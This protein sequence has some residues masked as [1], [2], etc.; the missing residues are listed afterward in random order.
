MTTAE[1]L[2]EAAEAFFR[3]HASD[4]GLEKSSIQ[5]RSVLNWGGFV[6][7]SYHVTDGRTRLHAKLSTT[8]DGQAALRRWY[9]LDA[10]LRRHHA[11]PVLDRLDV[12]GAKGLVFPWLEGT[13]PDFGGQV[14]RSVLG[15]AS[16]LWADAELAARLRTE[17]VV[18]ATECYLETYHDRFEAD[19]AGIEAERPAF[20]SAADLEY[21]RAEVDDMERRVRDAAAFQ[22]EVESPIHGDLWL[23][24]VL[25]Q[26]RR[27]WWLLD[28]DDVRIGDPAMDLAT[29]T[30]P[31]AKDLHPLKGLEVVAGAVSPAVGERLTLLGRA[32]L[33]DWV[34]DPLA[35]W[36]EAGLVPEHQE[37]VRPEKE[38]VHREALALYR[39]L[40]RPHTL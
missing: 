17:R 33:L 28:W 12:G 10:L 16:K 15:C 21:M 32:A 7:S 26:S 29:L 5:V 34:I 39:E 36:I 30:G 1:E 35:D 22:E 37:Q 8:A 14:A 40:Y 23:N 3:T 9:E 25:W 2:R 20:S 18:T 27:S 6:N 19:L 11:P 38:R 24:N 4:F 31:T 13:V